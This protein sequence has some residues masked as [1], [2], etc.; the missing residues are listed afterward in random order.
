MIELIF[1]SP[2]LPKSNVEKVMISSKANLEIISSIKKLEISIIFINSTDFLNI[3]ECSHPDML[4]YITGQG[5][6]ICEPSIYELYYKQ[7]RDNN[8][9]LIKGNSTLSCNYPNNI[10]YNVARVNNF[11]FHNT[12][13]TDRVITEYLENEN[14]RLI[15]INQGYAKCSICVV[16]ENAII[17]S[18]RSI[19]KVASRENLDVLLINEGNILL[20]GH[21]Y[22]FIG[23]ASF[24][25]NKNTICFTGILKHHPDYSKIQSFLNK[26]NISTEYLSVNK[27]IDFGS[28]LQVI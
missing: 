6:I 28:I 8:I 20:E 26:Y 11:A 9:I 13:Y 18:D 22:G 27:I 7:F 19:E 21:N 16:S 25:R 15:H 14:V 24:K 10:A 4:F 23:G 1:F 5:K 3:S 12:K 17:T 2:N